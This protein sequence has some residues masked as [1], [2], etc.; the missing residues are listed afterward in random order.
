M[1][2]VDIEVQSDKNLHL[3]VDEDQHIEEERTQAQPEAVQSSQELTAEET[4]EA[5]ELLRSLLFDDYRRQISQLQGELN[6]LQSLLDQVEGQINDKDALIMTLTPVIAGAIRTSIH[7]SREEMIDALYPITGRLVQRAVVESMRDLARRIDQQMRSTFDFQSL[8][9]RFQSRLHGVSDAE[10]TIRNAF[11]FQVQEI[12]LIHRE[13][14]LLLLHTSQLPDQTADSD[15]ISGMLTAIR[16]FTEDA[17]GHGEENELQQIQYG[18]QSILIEVAHLVYIALVI[19]GIEP[20]GLRA[21]M[22][23]IMIAIEHQHTALLRNYDGNAA[24]FVGSMPMLEVLLFP[25]HT[26]SSP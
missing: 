3:R 4:A 19:E 17:F 18:E 26:V 5:F 16:D 2:G 13:T 14:G 9:R 22:R 12:F 23:E 25:N 8:V 10:M 21:Q 1:N 20:S 7:D 15:V 24:A 6:R 11:A